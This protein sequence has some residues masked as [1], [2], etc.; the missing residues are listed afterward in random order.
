VAS[1]LTPGE[2]AQIRYHLGYPNTT[3]IA[4]FA[5]GVPTGIESSFI[6]ESAM[7][8]I[9]PEAEILVRKC[10]A[11]LEKLEAQEVEDQEIMALL[12]VDEI[13][14]NTKDM[15]AMIWQATKRWSQQ[16]GNIFGVTPNRFDQRDQ[17]SINVPVRH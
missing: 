5:I 6:L 13:E 11:I 8:N 10:V 9:Q 3:R 4:T 2:K 15:N 17:G 1:T 14:F 12:K 16:L 7:D